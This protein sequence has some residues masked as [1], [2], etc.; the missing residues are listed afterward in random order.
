MRGAPATLRSQ[1]EVAVCG[2][3]GL[4]VELGRTGILDK[5]D[6]DRILNNRGSVAGFN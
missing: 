1:S 3:P 4:T 2:R 6:N 5:N